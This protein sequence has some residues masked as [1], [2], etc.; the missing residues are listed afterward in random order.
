MITTQPLEDGV[1]TIASKVLSKVDGHLVH[2]AIIFGVGD[3]QIDVS[4]LESQEQSETTFVP[5]SIARFPGLVGQTIVLGG[6]IASIAIWSTGQTRFKEQIALIDSSFKA[7]FSK[8]IGFGVIAVFASNFIMLAVQT[9]RLEVSPFD[10]IETTFGSTWLTRMILTIIL[11]GIW[12]WIERKNQISFK[13]QLPMLVFALALIATTTM[14]G[15]GASTEMAPPII[16]DYVHNLLSSIWIGGV[17][18]LGFVV[19]P[20]ITKLDA[21]VRDKI[22][23]SFYCNSTL[24]TLLKCDRRNN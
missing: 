22:T 23:I 9:W 3:V 20:S 4:L 17:I 14:M 10:V 12:F 21:N 8:V 5:E 13:T 11:I 18:F 19:L 2:A 15:H 7:K 24:Y 16:L 6:V 1:Y